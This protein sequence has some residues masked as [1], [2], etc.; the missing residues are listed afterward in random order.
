MVGNGRGK[1]A[2]GAT[3]NGSSGDINE[4]GTWSELRASCQ[5]VSFFVSTDAISSSCRCDNAKTIYICFESSVNPR[6]I[7]GSRL[8]VVA[9][10]TMEMIAHDDSRSCSSKIL[11]VRGI[12]SLHN[13]VMCGYDGKA[14]LGLTAGTAG[15]LWLLRQHL[16]TGGK[17]QS[18]S[19]QPL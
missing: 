19:R 7:T 10:A 14:S 9:S 8:A 17:H 2:R 6:N 11:P 15:S 18:H 5:H 4:H 13:K 12:P 16:F 1:S 3:G